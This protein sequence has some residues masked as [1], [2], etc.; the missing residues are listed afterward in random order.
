MADAIAAALREFHPKICDAPVAIF[1]VGCFP[2]H[3]FVELSLLTAKELNEEPA[4]IDQAEMAAWRYYNFAFDL[5]AWKSTKDLVREMAD[6]YNAASDTDR[7]VISDAF[8]K[9]CAAAVASAEVTEAVSQLRRDVRFRVSVSHPDDG[10]E[11]FS[12]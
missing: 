6:A 1:A 9:A 3:G 2:W 7:E 4:L 12:V 11:F 10:R 5:A 8:F